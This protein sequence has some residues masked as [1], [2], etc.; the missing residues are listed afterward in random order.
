MTPGHLRDGRGGRPTKTNPLNL[1]RP[2]QNTSAPA[3]RTCTHSVSPSLPPLIPLSLRR[4]T[5]TECGKQRKNKTSASIGH[6]KQRSWRSPNRRAQIRD[7]RER[8]VVCVLVRRF[9][10][11]CRDHRGTTPLIPRRFRSGKVRA[12]SAAAILCSHGAFGYAATPRIRSKIIVQPQIRRC[13]KRFGKDSLIHVLPLRSPPLGWPAAEQSFA[14][15]PPCSWPVPCCA[16]PETTA[17]PPP[18]RLFWQK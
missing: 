15:P 17:G 14:A 16:R 6:Q 10:G 2:L 1:P 4:N 5:A 11:K 12:A 3:P 8:I 13:N 9:S 7:G 18:S